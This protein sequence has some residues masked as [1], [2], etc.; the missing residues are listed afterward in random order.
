MLTNK[1]QQN[2]ALGDD[3]DG[4]DDADVDDVDDDLRSKKPTQLHFLFQLM[5][6]SLY[7]DW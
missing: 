5:S 4:G 7:L 1:R 6:T 3:D 2:H